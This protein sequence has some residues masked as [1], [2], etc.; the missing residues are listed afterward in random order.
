MK[1]SHSV[2]SFL[3]PRPRFLWDEGVVARRNSAHTIE[4]LVVFFSLAPAPSLHQSP[5]FFGR[6]AT[7]F[8]VPI[9]VAIVGV[10]PAALCA[11]D[12]GPTGLRPMF[13]WGPETADED[14]GRPRWLQ[15]PCGCARSRLCHCGALH[16]I[17]GP[18]HP[19][20]Q[21]VIG[22]HFGTLGCVV[23]DCECGGV[24][25]LTHCKV[26]QWSPQAATWSCSGHPR[27]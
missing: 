6:R 15:A 19:H 24:P 7:P 16:P 9:F 23:H 25:H 26:S 10:P 20:G 17:L 2:R 12:C 5:D 1:T 4:L 27:L 8:S 13:S 22:C 14:C 21:L 3:R 18:W 11:H